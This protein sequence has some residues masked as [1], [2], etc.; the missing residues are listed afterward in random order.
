MDSIVMALVTC[1]AER[2]VESS[3][4]VVSRR[5]IEEVMRLL[6]SFGEDLDMERA[7]TLLNRPDLGIG[8]N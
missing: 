4:T 5:R 2:I 7:V 8:E 6:R 1:Y 3:D